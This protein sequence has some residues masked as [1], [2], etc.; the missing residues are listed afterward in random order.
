MT[1][2]FFFIFFFVCG[3]VTTEFGKEGAETKSQTRCNP[4]SHLVV[5]TMFSNAGESHIDFSK[6]T[7]LTSPL[8]PLTKKNESM[9]ASLLFFK[10]CL[11][12]CCSLHLLRRCFENHRTLWFLCFAGVLRK[13][14]QGI[15][16]HCLSY[17]L[18]AKAWSSAVEG[19]GTGAFYC[20]FSSILTSHPLDVF[21]P[22]KMSTCFHL[23]V[24]ATFAG[25]SLLELPC[26]L[27][28]AT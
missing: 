18:P 3:L 13:M 20:F 1:L 15:Q 9:D 27:P 2:F 26:F 5:S 17:V 28:L 22:K 21:E 10:D 8:S 24:S 19:K 25:L 11:P 7:F 16:R 14:Q 23:F 6:S 12:V 4:A